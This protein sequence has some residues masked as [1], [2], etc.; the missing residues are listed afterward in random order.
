MNKVLNEKLNF[1][2]AGVLRDRFEAL[3]GQM[4]GLIGLLGHE[5]VEAWLGPP[6]DD[7]DG[8]LADLRS[9]AVR[10]CDVAPPLTPTE[11]RSRLVDEITQP[12]IP[13]EIDC[14]RVMSLH[15]SKGLTAKLTII[16]G[17]AAGM[18]PFVKENMTPAEQHRS[19]QEQRRLFF[20]GI[21]RLTDTLVLSSAATMRTGEA[22]QMGLS[23]PGTAFWRRT[24]PSPFATQLGEGAPQEAIDGDGWL[25]NLGVP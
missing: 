18:I 11:L 17:F 5:F 3:T 25:T 22:A 4:N 19:M 24:A 1:T 6:A 9:M 15:K 23:L 10:A 21:T 2:D 8:R 14:V 12:E 20:V 7:P 16:T 13:T